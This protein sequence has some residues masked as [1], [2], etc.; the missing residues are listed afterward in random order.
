M[1]DILSVNIDEA[2]SIAQLPD[3]P[4]TSTLVI[5]ACIKT[6][7]AINPSI[8][9]AITD[10]ANGSYCYTK[11]Y[12]QFTP[13]I[14][15]PVISTAGAGDAFLAGIISGLCCGLPLCKGFNG[16]DFTSAELE[17]AVEL[18]TLLGS[19]SVTS[20]DTIHFGADAKTLYRFAKTNEVTFGTNFTMLFK[21]CLV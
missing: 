19:F 8:S 11:N 9:I 2:Q 21:D 10:G 17:S 15:V 5:E 1:V 7:T 12:L 20:P 4:V 18:G 13:A 3:D 6:L 14:K 16:T